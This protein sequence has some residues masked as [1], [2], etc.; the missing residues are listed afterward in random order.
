MSGGSLSS[1]LFLGIL[2]RVYG[3]NYFL[4]AACGGPS[5]SVTIV[6]NPANGSQN[7]NPK[8]YNTDDPGRLA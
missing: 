7:P 2:L 5:R 1:N 6:T 8:G 3:K 4:R